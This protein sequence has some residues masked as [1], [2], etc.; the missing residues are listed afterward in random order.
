M[1]KNI[2]QDNFDL[3]NFKIN[4]SVVVSPDKNTWAFCLCLCLI[5]LKFLF[6]MG[7]S[8]DR[9]SKLDFIEQQ[10]ILALQNSGQAFNE[11]S[12][13]KPS[14]KSVETTTTQF[15]KTLEGIENEISKQINYLTQVSPGQAHEGSSYAS[16]KVLHMAWHR[17]E[18]ART[19]LNELER[20]KATH[21]LQL[22]QYQG[23]IQSSLQSHHQ[24]QLQQPQFQTQQIPHQ[25]P[26]TAAPSQQL[27]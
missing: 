19:K 15:M 23:L 1:I 7:T 13:D 11:L 8:K 25:Q 21:Q 27:Y 5:D 16:Q 6:K 12:K 4:E 22:Q 26:P 14:L 3:L 9:L 24:Q 18:H 20:L 17:L 2:I 10:L